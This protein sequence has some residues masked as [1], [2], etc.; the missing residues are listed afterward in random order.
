MELTKAL[1]IANKIV[2]LLKPYC[3]KIDIA[4][5]C[6][7]EKSEVGDLEVC[8][9]PKMVVSK[10]DSLFG[11]DGKMLVSPE[12]AKIANGLGKVIKGKPDG[13][14]MQIELPQGINLDLFMPEPNDYYRIFAIRTGSADYSF[15]VIA[16]G[17]KKLGWCGSD[18]GFRK[19]SD[20]ERIGDKWKCVNPNAELAP[21]WVSEKDFFNWLGVEYLH[22]KNRSWESKK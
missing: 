2:A 21:V 20:C 22:P 8:A 1:P 19:I 14:Y 3:D 11:G 10:S 18:M 17:W 4:G 9:V 15:K 12:F 13:R 5:S 16:N 6:R 7:R